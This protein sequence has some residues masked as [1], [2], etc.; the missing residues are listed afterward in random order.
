MV[1]AHRSSRPERPCLGLPD[2]MEERGEPNYPAGPGTL[3]DGDGVREHV[4]VAVDRV[5]FKGE[6]RQLGEEFFG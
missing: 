6:G 5:L 3:H 1:E 4:L 2:V